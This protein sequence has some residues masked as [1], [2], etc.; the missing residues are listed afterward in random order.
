MHDPANNIRADF[1]ILCREHNGKPL[2]YLDNAATTQKPRVV[3]EALSRYYERHNANVHRAAHILAE[4][5]TTLLEQARTSVQQFI[6]AADSAEVIFT[7]GTTE[8]INLVAY[9]VTGELGPGDEILITEL[10]HHSNIVPWQLLAQRTG[11]T[12]RAVRVTP[13]GDLDLSD[14]EQRLSDRTRLFAC[15]HVSNAL[16]S[17]NPVQQMVAKARAAGAITL[18][19]G[20]QAT[21][22]EKIDVQA[23]DCD[24]YA[25]SGH[26]MYAP[27][28]IGVL[29]GRRSLLERLPP[30]H[31][32]G[33]M[34]E[35]VTIESSTYQGP[36]F[37]YEAGTPNIA[38]AVGLG[39][40]IG[41][42][43]QQ[44]TAKLVA[45]EAELVAQTLD[46]LRQ[47]PG[48]QLIGMPQRRSAVVSFLL[49]DGH[50]NDVGTLL[51]Q[52]GVAVRSGHHCTMPL[53]QA[54][55][56]PGT[57]RAS[58]SL[59]SNAEDVHRLL[60]AVDK[61]ATFL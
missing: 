18:V 9:I 1:P 15:N 22:H 54:L 10:D 13:E 6:H 38:G 48:V 42:L 32:G 29:Y 14:F 3:I 28:G 2:V 27:T 55:G 16:G 52:Q 60:T 58:F 7:R 59:Y 17:I 39:A 57:V 56:V 20:A 34:I 51:D 11:A 53:M 24:F 50:P 35:H 25:F 47:I 8:A 40:A 49:R 5:A 46:G 33:E 4:E 61:A 23:L 12:L 41:Y 21:L 44:P 43:N 26:K 31:G 36:P 30:W 19:D 45:A 37:K